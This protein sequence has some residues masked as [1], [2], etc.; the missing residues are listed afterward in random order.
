ML[1]KVSSD[2][3]HER[4]GPFLGGGAVGGGSLI[5]PRFANTA[6]LL[7]AVADSHN[8]IPTVTYIQLYKHAQVYY[9]TGLSL[10]QSGCCKPLSLPDWYD[11]HYPFNG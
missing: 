5:L 4:I 10:Q 11:H 1:G 6:Q 3:Y 9:S 7:D 2:V 8:Y